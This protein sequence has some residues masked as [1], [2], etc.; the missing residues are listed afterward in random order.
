MLIGNWCQCV[1][2]VLRVTTAQTMDRQRAHPVTLAIIVRQ[3]DYIAKPVH[4]VHTA[5]L[6]GQRGARRVRLASYRSLWV[7]RRL[8]HVWTVGRDITTMLMGR[9][10]ARRVRRGAT[11]TMRGPQ[12][13]L[14]SKQ[15]TT[16]WTGRTIVSTQQPRHGE[17]VHRGATAALP[18]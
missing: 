14:R 2:L 10:T 15:A 5:A 3:I 4:G 7:L 1:P 16:Q 13:V 8:P 6:P 17:L 12:S 18:G 9:Q 11:A